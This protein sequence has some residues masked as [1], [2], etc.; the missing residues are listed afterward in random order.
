MDHMA[1]GERVVGG[2]QVA[3]DGLGLGVGG[4]YT[5]CLIVQGVHVTIAAWG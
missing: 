1:K 4:G 5:R 3:R 2:L